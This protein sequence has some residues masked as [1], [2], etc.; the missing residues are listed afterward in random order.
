MGWLC[1]A[2][3]TRR[4]ASTKLTVPASGF[5]SPVDD[6][7]E[8]FD[9]AGAGHDSDDELSEG[10]EEEEEEGSELGDAQDSLDVGSYGSDAIAMSVTPDDAVCALLRCRLWAM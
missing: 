4:R 10:G 1:E 8:D 9:S 5:C 2:R 6:S 3:G 7:D